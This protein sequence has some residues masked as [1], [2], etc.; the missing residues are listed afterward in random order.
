MTFVDSQKFLDQRFGVELSKEKPSI[1]LFQMNGEEVS[2]P[3]LIEVQA[4][5]VEEAFNEIR[6][7]LLDA[8]DSL[9]NIQPEFRGN[10]R[11]IFT[12]LKQRLD[13][14]KMFLTIKHVARL[15]GEAKDLIGKLHS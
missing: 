9:R 14:R 7:T 5:T 3:C 10:T 12:Q 11:E 13:Q 4:T 6:D 15:A 2:N 1:L 8:V